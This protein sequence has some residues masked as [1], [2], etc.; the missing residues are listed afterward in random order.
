MTRV[1]VA[2]K[3]MNMTTKKMAIPK[4]TIVRPEPRSMKRV[5]TKMPKGMRVTKRTRTEPKTVGVDGR[6]LLAATPV[7]LQREPATASRGMSLM[8]GA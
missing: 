4:Q 7:P 1:I 5:K 2:P 8:A 6:H 3:G